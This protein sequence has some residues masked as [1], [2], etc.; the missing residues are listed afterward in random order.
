MEQ[1][2]KLRRS[3][4]NRVLGGVCSGI[5]NYFSLSVSNIRW[6]FALLIILG[7]L[8]FF[9]YIGMWLII[10]QESIQSNYFNKK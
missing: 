10:P 4:K 2:N 5:A 1:N 3:R 7:G 9:V 8:S 6:A